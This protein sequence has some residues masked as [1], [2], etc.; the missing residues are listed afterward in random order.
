MTELLPVENVKR[1]SILLVDDHPVVREGLALII[2]RVPG[3][4]VTH[5]ADGSERALQILSESPIDLVIADLELPGSSGLD[6]IKQAHLRWPQLPIMVLSAHPENV[7]ALRCIRAGA[8][9]YMMKDKASEQIANALKVMVQGGV[10]V[11]A[12][13]QDRLNQG[14]ASDVEE[15]GIDVSQLTD[16]ELEIFSLIGKGNGSRKIA[17]QLKLSVKTVEAHFANIKRKLNLADASSLT[18]RAVQWVEG[19]NPV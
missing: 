4:K 17:E 6:L 5:F 14:P 10:C 16:R 11:S 19:R 15:S 2:G 18:H 9:G 13:I 8:R 7:F 12:E 1:F 3:F